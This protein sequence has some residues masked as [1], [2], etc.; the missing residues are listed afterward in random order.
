MK[1]YR[2]TNYLVSEDGKVY[3]KKTGRYLKQTNIGWGGYYRVQLGTKNGSPKLVHRLVAEIYLPNPENKPEVNHIDG[4]KLNNHVSNLEWVTAKENA[5]H[6]ASLGL[7]NCFKSG[8]TFSK[9]GSENHRSVLT[10]EQVEEIKQKYKPFI[11]TYKDL[12][13]EYNVSYSTI[14]RILNNRTYQ[15]GK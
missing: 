3:N 6:A 7:K 10:L 14:S 4:N 11:Y 15:D 8:N 2:N 1:Q 12:T 5:K 9:K 13:K